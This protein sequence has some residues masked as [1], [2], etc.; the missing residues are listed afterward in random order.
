M[1]HL[2]VVREAHELLDKSL[3]AI[4]G[5][6]GLAPDDQLH[7]TLRIE[8]EIAQAV[9]VP[10]HE[11]EPLVGGDAPR[12]SDREDIRVQDA[13]DP[14]ELSITRTAHAPRCAE[15]G[16][17]ISDE[18]LAQH[19]LDRPDRLIGDAPDGLP[20]ASLLDQLRPHLAGGEVAHLACYPGRGVHAVGDRGDEDLVGIEARPETGEHPAAHGTVQQAHAIGTL[21]QAQAHH[22]H[23]EDAGIPTL[24]G[25][26]TQFEDAVDRHPGLGIV[27]A[28]EALDEFAREAIDA[29]GHRGV[30]GEDGAR[31]HR[32]EGRVEVQAP[33]DELA[34][35][36]ESE[37]SGVT[38]IG[39]E[40]LGGGMPGDLAV[41]PQGTHTADAEE[42]LLC[43]TVLPPAAVEPIG[44]VTIGW[45]VL[46]DIGVEE[47]Q[48][49]AADVSDPD[50]RTQG[51]S[52]GEADRDRDA[53]TGCIAQER[54]G[55]AVRIDDRVGLELPAL[56]RERLVEVA[57]SVEEPDTDDGYAEIRR[58]LE[59]IAREDAESS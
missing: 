26:R 13:V 41:A 44:D 18:L 22:G 14:S 54:H 30:G 2:R 39:V 3:A 55:Q 23:V 38:L 59:V 29:G 11:R 8:Q 47:E 24:E 50:T 25:L 7:G 34:H 32:L 45:I 5:R 17:R 40:D 56:P 37:E 49:D 28:E 20:S 19:A 58:R 4:I 43:E 51:A 16:A 46:L 33:H 27:A 35:A 31:A 12:E 9:G 52:P 10:E 36:L 6:M 48:V 21:R 1:A 53:L 57:G 42:H 15:P